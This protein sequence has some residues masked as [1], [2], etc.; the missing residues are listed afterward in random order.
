VDNNGSVV[1]FFVKEVKDIAATIKS[2]N[3]EYSQKTYGKSRKCPV[4]SEKVQSCS[5]HIEE[6]GSGISQQ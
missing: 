4:K 3:T 2:S 5:T 6:R 1:H